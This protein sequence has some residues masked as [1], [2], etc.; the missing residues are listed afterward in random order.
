MRFKLRTSENVSRREF[1]IF[2]RPVGVELLKFCSIATRLH[3]P[4]YTRRCTLLRPVYES[5]FW[6]SKEVYET[7]S[8][9]AYSRYWV[10]ADWC[11]SWP[12][13]RRAIAD[14]TADCSRRSVATERH[15]EL[16]RQNIAISTDS[17]LSQSS[18][19]RS[20]VSTVTTRSYI[21]MRRTSRHDI[22][23]TY[24]ADRSSVIMTSRFLPS[25]V[26]CC[27]TDCNF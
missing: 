25:V 23:W 24:E 21:C 2:A 12:W 16:S 5:S 13:L 17:Q 11:S 18:W 3:S 8:Q 15:T 20:T 10:P 19:Q 1:G 6:T 4:T 26:S 9:S 27:V 7:S 22:L 14:A